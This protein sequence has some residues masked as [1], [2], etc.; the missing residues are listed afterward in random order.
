[1]A[2]P[3]SPALRGGAPNSPSS[4]DG[5]AHGLPLVGPIAATPSA[6]RVLVPILVRS[7]TTADSSGAAAKTAAAGEVPL[8]TDAVGATHGAA[9]SAPHAVAGRQLDGATAA[10]VA[11][12]RALPSLAHTPSSPMSR[13]FDA[14]KA[15]RTPI[16]GRF[17]ESGS[18][19]RHSTGTHV[20]CL[21]RWLLVSECGSVC[22]VESV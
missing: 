11:A 18:R 3:E 22:C 10:G 13:V 20:R 7:R 19:S 5:G 1:M 12:E 15:P 17:D 16:L 8:A 4:H 2:A 9:G 14:F 21:R 6:R